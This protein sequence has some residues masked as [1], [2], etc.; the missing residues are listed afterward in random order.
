MRW[1]LPSHQDIRI[2]YQMALL[3]TF[4]SQ[5]CLNYERIFSSISLRASFFHNFVIFWWHK[6]F[7]ILREKKRTR[8]NRLIS[9]E[10][11]RSSS[12]RSNDFVPRKS[13]SAAVPSNIIWLLWKI[14]AKDGGRSQWCAKANDAA[15][16]LPSAPEMA[17][18]CCSHSLQYINTHTC[19]ARD[20]PIICRAHFFT[21]KIAL[22][23]LVLTF[24]DSYRFSGP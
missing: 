1:K 19:W 4:I 14:L 22:N 9:P 15:D 12:S 17:P 18:R 2:N 10:R 24:C 13:W 23:G 20:A 3:I 7:F 11:Q 5:A 6:V 16:F 21:Q 8:S